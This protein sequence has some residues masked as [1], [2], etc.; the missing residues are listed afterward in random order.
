MSR[1][2]AL[3][4]QSG[5]D[6]CAFC[7]WRR[8][9]KW[10]LIIFLFP[11][12]TAVSSPGGGGGGCQ[13]NAAP[14][15]RYL[16]CHSVHLC[17]P[18]RLFHSVVF[19]RHLSLFLRLLSRLIYLFH[20]FPLIPPVSFSFLFPTLF[21]TLICFICFPASITSQAAFFFSSVMTF[22]FSSIFSHFSFHFL[23]IFTS[24]FFQLF[25]H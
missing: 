10:L 25:S 16:P 4:R 22:Y 14:P 2:E 12:L 20:L 7:R 6:R 15:P 23:L 9:I 18:L 24:S 17:L 21:F 19:F 8:R 13:I 3:Q 5:R 1:S 11:A